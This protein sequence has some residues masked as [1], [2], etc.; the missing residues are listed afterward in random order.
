MK[1][2]SPFRRTLCDGWDL[3]CDLALP[4]YCYPAASSDN[5][6]KYLFNPLYLLPVWA[7]AAA[8]VAG[9]FGRFLAW[10]LPANGMALVFAILMFVA[11][12]IRTSFRGMA[13]SVSFLENLLY[14]KK[15][16]E[17][18]AL[19]KS[20]LRNISGVA[21]LLLAVAATG[22]RFF[23]LFLA[24]KS[25]N[26]GALGAAWLIAFSAEGFLAAEPAAVNMPSFC[27]QAKGEYIVAIAGFCLLFN[28]V[29]MPLATLIATGAAAVLVIAMMNLLLK[30]CNRITSDD[31]TMTGY[32]LELI[33]LLIFAVMVG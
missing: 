21:P 4:A 29:F 33:V 15:F 31:M 24:A 7:A 20:D 3:I 26:Y 22:V 19:R 30:N 5:R 9:L 25:S 11:C 23:A 27:S 18:A 10:L 2:S 6:S 8:V 1:N 12:E 14:G 17:A 32:F 16:A 13:L 28:L